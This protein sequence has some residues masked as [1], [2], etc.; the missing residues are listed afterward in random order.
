[1]YSR[2]GAQGPAVLDARARLANL[3]LPDELRDVKILGARFGG[4]DD[5]LARVAA[6]TGWLRAGHRYTTTPPAPA[7]GVDPVSN[8]LFGEQQGH[9]EYFASAA[10]L[11]LRAAG[12]PARYVTGFRGGEWNTLGNY[13]AVRGDRAHAWAEAF[14]PGVG[15]LRVDATPPGAAAGTPAGLAQVGDALDF[16]WN[17]WIVGYDLGRQRAL[18]HRAWRTLVGLAPSGASRPGAALGILLAAALLLGV[19]LRIRRGRRRRP[20]LGGTRVTASFGAQRRS[21]GGHLERLYRRS[22]ERLRRRGWPRRASETPHEYAARLR[23]AGVL[24]ETAAFQD[25]TDR[26]AAARFGDHTVGPETI[27]ALGDSLSAAL[28]R[29]PPQR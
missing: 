7:A 8:F 20:A 16:F 4:A 13:V 28:S 29:L 12:V 1:V 18:L 26:Y 27:A 5:A 24:A 3:Q 19:A 22:T 11:L 2:A 15:W 9:C 21:D 17:R 14:L 6:I 25:L 10:V 23:A